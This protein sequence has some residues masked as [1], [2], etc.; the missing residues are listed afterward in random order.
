M[1]EEAHT[2]QD[3]SKFAH[4]DEAILPLFLQE[5]CDLYHQR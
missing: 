3:L 2:L 1:Q 5:I 4:A